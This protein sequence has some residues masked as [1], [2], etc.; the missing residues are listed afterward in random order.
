VNGQASMA[1]ALIL[2]VIGAVCL[3]SSNLVFYGIMDE[4]NRKNPA[5]QKINLWF[6]NLKIFS[7]L[8]HHRNFFPLSR[9]RTT[10]WLL[11]IAGWLLLLLSWLYLVYFARR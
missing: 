3:V 5:D 9:K 11:V 8:R 6:V 2:I 1:P 10:M 4:V 7:V